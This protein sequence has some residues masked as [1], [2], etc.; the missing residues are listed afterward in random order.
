MN[1]NELNIKKK[2]P[3]GSG[4]EH[5]AFPFEK[6]KDL[7]I[8][9]KTGMLQVSKDVD[10]FIFTSKDMVL[11]PGETKIFQDHPEICAKV[12]KAT[13]RYVVLEKLDVKG[14][15]K[16]L[17]GIADAMVR[18]FNEEP[19]LA[20]NF[21]LKDPLHMTAQDFDASVDLDRNQNDQD[22]IKGVIKYSTNRNF[23]IKFL[24]FLQ[25]VR[26]SGINKM[27]PNNRRVDI[28]ERNIGYDK[29]RNIKLLDI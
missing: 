12:Y 13:D 6:F 1:I 9:T 21:S 24:K 20:K 28:H 26:A 11:N 19:E 5:T 4:V 8:K 16:D 10:G 3:L 29:Q 18:L 14:L 23:T 15:Q 2:E 25:A 22:F 7:V 17:E 27:L